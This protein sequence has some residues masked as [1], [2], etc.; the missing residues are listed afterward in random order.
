MCTGLILKLLKK[1]ALIKVVSGVEHHQQLN[2]V[3]LLDI[4][5][6]D[7][8]DFIMIPGGADRSLEWLKYL[9]R[10]LRGIGKQGPAPAPGSERTDRC[11]GEQWCV[12]W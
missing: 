6:H 4:D 5:P 7:V 2:L 11:Q 8:A 12:D 10:D 1:D 3:V 9:E